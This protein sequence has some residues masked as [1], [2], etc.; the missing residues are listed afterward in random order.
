M[1]GTFNFCG[2]GDWLGNGWG[3]NRGRGWGPGWW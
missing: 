2:D 3:N 1:S